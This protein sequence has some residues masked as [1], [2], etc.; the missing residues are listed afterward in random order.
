VSES[1]SCFPSLPFHA[2]PAHRSDSLSPSLSLVS[3]LPA[4]HVLSK[5]MDQFYLKNG[6]HKNRCA[7]VSRR[8]AAVRACAS[9]ARSQCR[10]TSSY[11]SVTADGVKEQSWSLSA[12]MVLPPSLAISSMSSTVR[13]RPSC[14]A[15]RA[16]A[17]SSS[18]AHSA[19]AVLTW[20]G[21]ARAP[22]ARA[23]DKSCAA[24]ASA[25][26]RGT[27]RRRARSAQRVRTENDA[28]GARETQSALRRAG[29]MY[30]GPVGI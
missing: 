27:Y 22:R 11:E 7:F 6:M 20:S 29:G 5:W 2:A 14:L 17:P 26:I 16:P 21:H 30:I 12:L 4:V 25:E 23:A 1:S 18:H 3:R 8:T 28:G 13:A 15:P 10:A 24:R 9:H 19:M